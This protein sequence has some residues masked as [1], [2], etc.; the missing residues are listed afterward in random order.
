[1]KFVIQRVK[2][3]SVKVDDEYTGKMKMEKQIVH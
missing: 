3:A 1:M 2:K